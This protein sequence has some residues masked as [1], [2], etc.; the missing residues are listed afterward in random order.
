MLVNVEQ[1]VYSIALDELFREIFLE[2]GN[3]ANEDE[4]ERMALYGKEWKSL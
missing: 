1:R 3:H 2:F 4:M